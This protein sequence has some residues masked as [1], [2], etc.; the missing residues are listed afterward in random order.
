MRRKHEVVDGARISVWDDGPKWADRYTVVYLDDALDGLYVPYVTMGADPFCPLGFCQHVEMPL[1]HV[2]YRGR[3]GVFD[4]R[5]AFA[6]LPVDCQR[7]VH[8]DLSQE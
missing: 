8:Q 5:I 3:G 2:A 4:R 6:D 7:V 1:P